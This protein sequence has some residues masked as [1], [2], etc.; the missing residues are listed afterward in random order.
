MI[1]RAWLITGISL[2]GIAWYMTVSLSPPNYQGSARSAIYTYQDAGLMPAAGSLT[3]SKEI[4]HDVFEVPKTDADHAGESP[5]AG[6]GGR[7]M[8]GMPGMDMKQMPADGDQAKMPGMSAEKMPGMGQKQDHSGKTEMAEDGHGA[9]GSGLAILK[10]SSVQKVDRA[11]E[12]K[13]SEWGYAPGSVTVKEGEVI[14]LIV[15]NAGNT[16]HE[17]MLMTG[18]EMAAVGY[19]ANRADWNLTEHEAIF[20]KPLVMPGDRFEVVVKIEKPGAWMFMCMFPYHM[21]LGMMGAL[22]TKGMEGM[23]MGGMKM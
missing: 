15:T 6:M 20:E 10:T 3:I 5:M 17:F 14:R 21:Q 12:I 8:S 2:I 16:P 13:M 1:V 7:S 22:A 23:N 19:R 9:G 11:I 18:P 4:G